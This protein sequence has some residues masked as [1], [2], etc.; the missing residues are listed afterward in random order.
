MDPNTKIW[1]ATTFNVSE[2][3]YTIK[4]TDTG[5]SGISEG[6]LKTPYHVYEATVK[7]FG[8]NENP[9]Q[10]WD[11]PLTK[12][13]RNDIHVVDNYLRCRI[14][15]TEYNFNMKAKKFQVMFEGGYMDDWRENTDTPYVSVGKCDKID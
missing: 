14:M 5:R 6:I 2:D 13:S 11:F 1:S 4:I 10:C 12:E 7:K 8:S 9:L 3:A 15:S